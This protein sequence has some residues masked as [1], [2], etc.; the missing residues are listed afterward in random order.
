MIPAIERLCKQC[1]DQSYNFNLKSHALD[2]LKQLQKHVPGMEIPDENEQDARELNNLSLNDN[3]EDED[4]EEGPIVL[5]MDEINA[6]IKS[7]FF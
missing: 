3:D 5:S 2:L 6:L 7:F 1:K 4:D